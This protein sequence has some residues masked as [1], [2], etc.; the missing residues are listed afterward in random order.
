M[1]MAR[2]LVLACTLV[3]ASAGA[4]H[5]AA[6]AHATNWWD[7]LWRTLTIVMVLG[8]I[9]KAAGKKALEFFSGRRTGIEQELYDLE[10]RKEQARGKLAEVE[11]RISNLE[12]ERNAILADYQARGEALK[13]EILAKAQ[14][15]AAQLTAQAKQAA[16][17]EI[18]QAVAAMRAE[19]AERIAVA[20]KDVLEKNLSAKEHEKLIDTFL[21]KVVLQ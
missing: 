15:S 5:A 1:H 18:D 8:V 12:A 14:A 9:W 2:T 20:A 19:M 3:L 10:A 17:N 21:A 16:Q 4:A 7:L 6:E 11:A 13:A